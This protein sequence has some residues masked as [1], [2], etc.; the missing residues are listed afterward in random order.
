[1]IRK[2]MEE[3]PDAKPMLFVLSDGETNVGYN[4]NDIRDIL[5]GLKIPVYTIGYNADLSALQS[6]SSVNEAAS[7]DAS[8]DDVVYQL[9]TLFNA[10]M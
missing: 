2:Q 7:I 5:S 10:N 1:M 8:T 6:I 9:K 4:L 3:Y